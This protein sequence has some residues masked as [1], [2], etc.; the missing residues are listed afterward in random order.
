MIYNSTETGSKYI[1]KPIK[2]TKNLKNVEVT[3]GE[4]K[5]WKTCAS[6]YGCLG[7]IN[8]LT[9]GMSYQTFSQINFT[10]RHHIY[11]SL[12]QWFLSFKPS[13]LLRCLKQ[14]TVWIG[15]IVSLKVY[16]KIQWGWPLY[17][18]CIFQ[19]AILPTLCRLLLP[20]VQGL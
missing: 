18:L 20:N 3:A 8:I 6:R 5:I 11:S 12:R 1:V 16:L 17:F 2:M 15:L 10:K 13:K 7:N 14:S 4:F 9:S 19:V